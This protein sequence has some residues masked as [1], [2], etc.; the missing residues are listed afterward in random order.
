[1][2]FKA[3]TC[4]S[5]H[6]LATRSPVWRLRPHVGESCRW[7]P[8]VRSHPVRIS[9]SPV[10]TWTGVTPP[11]WTGSC[12]H[13]GPVFLNSWQLVL[14]KR[15]RSKRPSSVHSPHSL[16]EVNLF[17]SRCHSLRATGSSA[18]SAV[19]RKTFSFGGFTSCVTG[20]LSHW[21]FSYVSISTS[22]PSPCPYF[23]RGAGERSEEWEGSNVPSRT[24]CRAAS[25]EAA[26]RLNSDPSRRLDQFERAFP[27]WVSVTSTRP[28]SSLIW[29][30]MARHPPHWLLLIVLQLFIFIYFYLSGQ[31]RTNVSQ[32]IRAATGLRDSCVD[33]TS[34]W[35]DAQQNKTMKKTGKYAID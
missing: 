35:S 32:G 27:F 21:L 24:M 15:M 17:S 31:N 14:W 33:A 11:S 7:S 23:N 10:G 4:S 3:H 30:L 1:M 9:S 12:C 16:P 25:R 13:T 18:L 26:G 20:S 19:S 6:C 34:I 29:G 28:T 2:A 22:I 5:V 8:L